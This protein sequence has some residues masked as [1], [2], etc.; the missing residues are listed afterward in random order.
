VGF[1]FF[2]LPAAPKCSP[3]ANLIESIN[4]KTEKIYQS[5][6]NEQQEEMEKLGRI[7]I[8]MLE[9][10]MKNVSSVPQISFFSLFWCSS[11]I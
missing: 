5:V 8:I 10:I 4:N 3:Q 9:L 6:L 7:E 1:Y 11:V 2:I